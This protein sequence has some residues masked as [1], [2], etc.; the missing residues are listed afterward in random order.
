MFE[1]Y[2]VEKTSQAMQGTAT[3]SASSTTTG[4]TSSIGTSE[5]L[6]SLHLYGQG[7]Q[8]LEPPKE[9]VDNQSPQFS[10]SVPLVL[11]VDE[12]WASEFQ[13]K[14]NAG[15]EAETESGIMVG[16]SVGIPEID[17]GVSYQFVVQKEGLLTFKS[18]SVVF[19]CFAAY[20]ITSYRHNLRLPF[21]TL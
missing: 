3:T 18:P 13:K 21:S 10:P 11:T 12:S 17:D 14:D 6:N 8:E 16:G 5:P 15:A 20:L 2:P 19:H 7:S 9:A 1:A 4:S